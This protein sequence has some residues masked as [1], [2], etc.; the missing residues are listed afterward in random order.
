MMQSS[1]RGF[2][3]TLTNMSKNPIKPK[4]GLKPEFWDRGQQFLENDYTHTHPRPI[5]NMNK[6][7]KEGERE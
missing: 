2:F 7:A 3:V 1:N 4:S 6:K 5:E